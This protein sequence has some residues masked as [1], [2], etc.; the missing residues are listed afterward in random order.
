MYG[1]RILAA[2]GVVGASCALF[3]LAFIANAW[4][5]IKH[6][7]I[8]NVPKDLIDIIKLVFTAAIGVLTVGAISEWRRLKQKDDDDDGEEDN[9]T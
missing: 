3:L 9:G 2:L 5:V 8:Y 6:G 1:G 7:E 4:T